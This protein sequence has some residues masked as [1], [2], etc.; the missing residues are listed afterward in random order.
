M[1]GLAAQSSTV[2]ALVSA[3][4][5]PALA[6]DPYVSSINNI[7]AFGDSWT[8][9]GYNPSND[10]RKVDVYNTTSGGQVWIQ[11]LANNYT[12][13]ENSLYDFAQIGATIDNNLVFSNPATDFDHQVGLFENYFANSSR[14]EA[15]KW[16]ANDT[17]FAIWFGNDDLYNCF[18]NNRSFTDLVPQ[19]LTSYDRA[20]AR[21]Y[22]NGARNFV[23]LSLPELSATPLA[24]SSQTA[25]STLA[26]SV[27]AWNSQLYDYVSHLSTKYQDA[28]VTWYD[29]QALTQRVLDD[30]KSFPFTNLNTSCKAYSSLVNQP[31]ADDSSCNGSLEQFLW[32]NNWN[33]TFTFHQILATSIAIELEEQETP[34]PISSASRTSIP[35]HIAFVVLLYLTL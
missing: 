12:S 13:A 20:F 6:A 25:I 15:I 9:N 11:Y 33:P 5:S 7:F 26:P 21:L 17:L 35:Y 28:N 8:S 24:L 19:L 30:P 3:L 4:I 2:L 16:K 1:F 10:L 31:D 23:I 34:T 14:P 18:T 27:S 29:T 32:K 22:N